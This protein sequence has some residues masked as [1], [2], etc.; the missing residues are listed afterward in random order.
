MRFTSNEILA[1]TL[2]LA[3]IVSFLVDVWR[4]GF[5][6]T[7]ASAMDSLDRFPLLAF[8]LVAAF[9]FAAVLAGRLPHSGAAGAQLHSPFDRHLTSA[10]SWTAASFFTWALRENWKRH[11]TAPG[12][13][14]A[15]ACMIWAAVE[16]LLSLQKEK[17]ELAPCLVFVAGGV[18][19][20]T[21]R[22]R[23]RKQR[24]EH[25]ILQHVATQ[26]DVLQPEYHRPTPECPE[27]ERWRMYDS[28][29]AEYEVLAFLQQLVETLKPKLIVETGTFMGISTLKLAEGLKA[30]GAGKVITCEYDPVVYARAVERIEASGLKDW[31]D[32][33]NESS[34]EMKV[35]GQ[36]DML[37][38]DSEP[39]LREAEVRRYL[40][41]LRPN[42]VILI[43]DASSH[44]KTV[45]EAALKLERE[46]LISVVLLPTPR[47]LV[48]AQKREHRTE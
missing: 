21:V 11:P 30:N 32:A 20:A 6:S 33:R 31:I 45:R 9:E 17:F 14:F 1:L 12:Q 39:E 27:P 2:F 23:F 47:G 13:L 25:R 18:L 37:F 38:S 16:T 19:L 24:G 35:D 26:G 4:K 29:T 34:L 8:S 48:I 5:R 22:I 44:L 10:M 7:F 3:L 15:S 28:M 46:G 42:A 36:I 43:H 41:M 40:P